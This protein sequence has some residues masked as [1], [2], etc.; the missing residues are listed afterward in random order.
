MIL[1][2]APA[3]VP[4]PWASSAPGT[5]V[6]SIAVTSSVGGTTPSW[7]QGWTSPF[8]LP[9]G[10]GGVPP[11]IQVENTLTQFLSAGLQYEQMGGGTFFNSTLSTNMGGYPQ[12]AVVQSAST[13]GLFWLNQVDNNSNNPDVNST[14]W[15]PIGAVSRSTNSNG[16]TYGWPKQGGG[17]L[18]RMGGQ[19]SVP[20]NSGSPNVYSF[21]SAFSTVVE[22]WGVSFW[23]TNPQPFSASIQPINLTQFE[24]TIPS[25]GSG[26]SFGCQWWAEGY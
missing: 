24:I 23:G 4:L 19:L 2:N 20:Y 16:Y 17:K 14:G 12:G 5:L 8:E 22:G 10:S 26:G 11:S 13:V 18:L 21:P 1:A 7:Q 6:T 15:T 3:P 9:G 25:A